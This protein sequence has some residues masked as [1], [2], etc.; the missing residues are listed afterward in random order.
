MWESLCNLRGRRV[1]T[2]QTGTYR[3]PCGSGKRYEE[4]CGKFDNVISIAQVKWRRASAQLR[5]RL[6]A[7]AEEAI[8]IKEVSRAQELF[9]REIEHDLCTVDED[10]IIERCFEWFIFDYRLPN[11]YRIIELF[12]DDFLDRLPL[13]EALLLLLWQ[14]A[15][16]SFYEVKAVFPNKGFLVE[17]LLDGRRCHVRNPGVPA[18][19]GTGSI[20][21]IRLLRVGE[22]YEF[23]TSALSLP[24]SRKGDLLDWVYKDHLRWCHVNRDA[25]D[26]SWASYLRAQAHKINGEV[27]RLALGAQA[28]GLGKQVEEQT[29]RHLISLLDNNV[30]RQVCSTREGRERLEE[31]LLLL[32][33]DEDIERLRKQLGIRNSRQLVRE[34]VNGPGGFKW[35]QPAYA[36]V[37]RLVSS[38]LKTLGYSEEDIRGALRLWYDFCR[39][40]KPYLKKPAA[41]AAAII[42]TTGRLKGRR[43][44][45][46]EIAAQNGVAVSSLSAN[47]RLLCRTLRFRGAKMAALEPILDRILQNLK[48]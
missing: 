7:F 8:F 48:L 44:S 12:K 41:W 11:G 32:D 6:A 19:I 1:L 5:R 2:I 15:Y 34:P 38:G 27:I 29:V 46:S 17:S 10:F 36:E 14:E 23:S 18:E 20:L 43:I 45:Q 31:L 30:L 47:F 40:E 37:A 35:P 24:A 25:G 33:N 28:Q 16:C 21:F 4:C 13:T 3:C 39:L 26:L 9:F 42:Y 22:E